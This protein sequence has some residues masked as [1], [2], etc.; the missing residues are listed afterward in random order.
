MKVQHFSSQIWDHAFKHVAIYNFKMFFLFISNDLHNCFTTDGQ[1][2]GS[3]RRLQLSV[4]SN[5][6]IDDRVIKNECC[7]IG[8]PSG[9]CLVYCYMEDYIDDI[10]S[11]HELSYVVTIIHTIMGFFKSG[12]GDT[13]TGTNLHQPLLETPLRPTLDMPL[14]LTAKGLILGV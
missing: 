1:A 12:G 9:V 14:S 2:D 7:I 6:G 13:L 10:P 11:E 4:T 3:D 5:G 8:L